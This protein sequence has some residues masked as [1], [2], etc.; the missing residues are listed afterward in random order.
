MLL[1]AFSVP[2]EM[3]IFFAYY[4]TNMVYYISW[5]FKIEI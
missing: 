5:T 1:N 4:S 3:I 2:M